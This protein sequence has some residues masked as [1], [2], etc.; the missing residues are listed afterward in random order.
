MTERH[1]DPT[2]SPDASAERLFLAAFDGVPQPGTRELRL[3]DRERDLLARRFPTAEFF[4]DQPSG[5]KTWY[6]VVI[7]REAR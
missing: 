1:N 2:L 3:S 7:P 4:P 6:R 5:D